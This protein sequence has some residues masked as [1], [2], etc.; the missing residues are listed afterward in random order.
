M[1]DIGMA[2]VLMDI[3]AQYQELPVDTVAERLREVFLLGSNEQLFLFLIENSESTDAKTVYFQDA[4]SPANLIIFIDLPE[5]LPLV[6]AD[7]TLE[8][9]SL[10]SAA[11]TSYKKSGYSY[12]TIATD[13]ITNETFSFSK[14]KYWI[15][16]DG[17]EHYVINYLVS[18]A[19]NNQS[20][21]I[22][23]VS[24]QLESDLEE[25]VRLLQLK[26]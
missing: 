4:T 3:P 8:M 1:D 22:R 17:K 10:S 7:V 15:R 12:K 21:A 11:E 14:F 9:E 16:R 20:F 23:M 25:S 5:Y 2:D 18:I 13:F 26:E 24:T 6:E 19:A